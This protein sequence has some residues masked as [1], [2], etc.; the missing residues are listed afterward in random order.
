MMHMF[1]VQVLTSILEM[2]ACLHSQMFIF[3]Q[4]VRVMMQLKLY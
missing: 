3:L 4:M 1:M 2:V